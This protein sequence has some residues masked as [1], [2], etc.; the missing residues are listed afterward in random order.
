M[1]FLVYQT[2]KS[3]NGHLRYRK[4]EEVKLAG[5]GLI[6]S[7]CKKFLGTQDVG[8]TITASDM[9]TAGGYDPSRHAL[10]IDAAPNRKSMFCSCKSK[11][12]PVIAILNGPL[13]CSHCKDFSRTSLRMTKCRRLRPSLKTGIVFVTVCASFCICSVDI[14]QAVGIG[15]ATAERRQR[16]YG[17]TRGPTLRASRKIHEFRGRRA[18]DVGSNEG[19]FLFEVCA[20]PLR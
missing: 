17:M 16:C 6:Y 5:D 18:G 4:M 13:S 7:A 1:A 10:I 20:P 8:W 9:L 15:E 12:Y 2:S 11:R 14:K 3:E 19:W